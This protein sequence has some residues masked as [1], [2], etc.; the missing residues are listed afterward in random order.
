VIKLGLNG[1]AARLR[2]RSAGAKRSRPADA[3]AIRAGARLSIGEAALQAPHEIVQFCTDAVYSYLME[4]GKIENKTRGF[5]AGNVATM[6]EADLEAIENRMELEGVLDKKRKMLSFREALLN[7]APDAWRRPAFN[8]DGSVN[9]SPEIILILR[10][11]MTAG[12]AVASSHQFTTSAISCARW[13]RQSRS[14]I[15][16]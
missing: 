1:I 7:K 16:R 13:R 6:N 3:G 15:G 8:A 2:S 9:P 10:T 14:K 11:L 4:G 12:A 5:A